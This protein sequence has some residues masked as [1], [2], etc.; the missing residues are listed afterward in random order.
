MTKGE[1]IRICED[2][3]ADMEKDANEIDGKPFD[4]KTVGEQFG[5]QAAAIKALA[6]VIKHILVNKQIEEIEPNDKR[7]IYCNCKYRS[8]FY[9]DKED[10]DL[11]LNATMV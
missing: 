7:L 1:L 11:T 3:A 10:N 2:V 4:G 5:Y 9:K 8:S 6:S